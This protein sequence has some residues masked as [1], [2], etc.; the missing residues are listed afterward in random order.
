MQHRRIYLNATSLVGF[1]VASLVACAFVAALLSTARARQDS[2]RPRRTAPS[3]KDA[4]P[5]PAQTQKTPSPTPS[6]APTLGT[7]SSQGQEIDPDEVIKVDTNL[8]N[9]QVRVVDRSNHP[10]NDVRR[11]DFHVFEDGVPQTI[12]FFTREE[13]PVSYG[14]VVDNSGS[15]RSQLQKVIDSA[16]TIVESN[17]PGD[18]TFLVRF[19]SSDKIET[20]QD[21]TSNKEALMDA[22]DNMYVEG[23]QTAVL[24]A[25]Y[26][27]AER[28]AQ[29][30][31]GNALNDRRRRA[32]ILVTDGEDRSSYYKERQLFES[33]RE[34]DVQIYIIGFVNELDKEG[35][36]IHKSPR[37]KGSA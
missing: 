20:L 34:E 35:G 12:S 1:L 5:P 7:Q 22:L 10:I 11:E 29:Y 14:L 8:V 23:G 25:V 30:K 28:V 31:K 18:E 4:P 19:I 21:F 37:D 36:L 3:Q 33:L 17:R 6:P 9:L 13:V 15:M 16:R 32:L 2:A 26:L 24:D 27:S